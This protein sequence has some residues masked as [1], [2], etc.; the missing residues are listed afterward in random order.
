[1]KEI[2]RN[3]YQ[4]LLS[5]KA[6]DW[7]KPLLLRGARQTGKT[8]LVRQFA[9]EYPHFIE[10]NLEKEA[11]RA[12]FDKTDNISDTQNAIF[13]VKQ[14][15]INKQPVLLFIDEI[16]E[17]PK[18]IQMLRYFYEERPEIHV[19]AAGSLL[20]FSL[21][22]VPSFPVGRIEYACLHPVNFDEFLGIMNPQAREVLHQIP[23]PDFAFEILMKLFHEY[24]IVGGMPE[25]VSRY[26]SEENIAALAGVYQQLWKTYKEDAE[27]YTGNETERRI[28]RHVIDAAPKETDR[29][30]FEGFGYSHYRSREVGEALRALDMARVIQLVYPTS[31]LEAPIV[32]NLRKRPRLQFLDTGMLTQILMLQGEMIGIQD[33]NNFFRGKI[34]Q[35]LV[36][37]ELM[38][39][40]SNPDFRP[41]FWVREEKDGNAE[42]DLVYQYGQ[43][44]IPI[45]VKSGKQGKLKSLHQF[46]DRSNHPYAIR[47]S[48]GRFSVEEAVTPGGTKYF[49]MNLPYFLGTKIPEYIAFFFKNYPS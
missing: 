26:S 42:V 5:W 32:P 48:A 6:S 40:Q 34:I 45:E 41:N 47:I 31:S 37:Q 15:Q 7:R 46:V 2:N 30:K 14:V 19:I 21:R 3:A 49:L 4:R 23:T 16:Q 28:I 44:V 24:A 9:R 36:C 38:S 39:L 43:H 18:A 10:L 22:K 25:V 11:D 20:E 1:M 17:S 13:L 8:T 35:H 27:K 29:I 33:L 12:I